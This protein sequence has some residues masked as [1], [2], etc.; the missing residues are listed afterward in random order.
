MMGFTSR[1]W[2]MEYNFKRCRDWVRAGVFEKILAAVNDAAD[3][4]MP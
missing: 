3:L 1:V 2:E 4:D